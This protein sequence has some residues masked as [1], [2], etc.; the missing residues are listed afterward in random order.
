[1]RV[2]REIM[3]KFRDRAW[4]RVDRSAGPNHCWPWTGSVSKAN[5]LPILH[6]CG[7]GFVYAARLIYC[8]LRN[9]AF[10][11]H[12]KVARRCDNWLCCNPRHLE[13]HREGHH[14]KGRGP[15]YKIYPKIHEASVLW[16]TG[17][18]NRTEL[19]ERYGVDRDVITRVMTRK[20]YK[21]A[22]RCRK[23]RKHNYWRLNTWK[24]LEIRSLRKKGMSLADLSA[25]FGVCMSHISRIARGITFSDV[26]EDP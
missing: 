19:S 5:K 24:V 18:M 10:P 2:T 16:C 1:M 12:L 20:S 11:S 6:V 26:R 17:S 8:L 23:K 7:T 14:P 15:R 9:R 4:S 3:I 13:L 25:M 22:P 21:D